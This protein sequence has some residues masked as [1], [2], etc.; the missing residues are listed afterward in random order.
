MMLPQLAGGVMFPDDNLPE[1][2]KLKPDFGLRCGRALWSRYSAGGTYFSFNQLPEMQETRN[3]G[4][5]MQSPEKYKNWFTNGSPIGAKSISQNEAFSST[6]GMSR[7]QRKALVNISYD[8]F[9]P[10]RKLSNVLLSVLSDND[11]KVKC[12]SLDKNI[13]NKKRDKKLDIQVKSKYTNPLLESLNLPKFQLPF[14][15]KDD[16]MIE[17]ADRLGFFKTKYEV[18]FEKIAEAGF[19]SS[20]WANMRRDLNRDAIDFHFRAAKI[21]NDE[22]TG[23]VK[24]QYID[25]ARLVMLWNEDNQDDPVAI[26]HIAVETIQSMYPKLKEAGFSDEKIQAMA[27]SYV[28]YQTDVTSL[29]QWAFEKKDPT[30]NRW[31]WMDFKVYVLKFEYLSTDYKQFVERENKHGYVTYLRNNKPVEEKKKNPNETYDEFQCN[32]WYEGSYII[33]GTGQDM[34]YEWRKKPNQM[35]KGLTPLSSYVVHRIGGQSPTRSVKGL[36]DDLMFAI[37][38]LRAAVWAAAP[39]GYRIDVSESAN[40]K[41]GGVEY[42]L[43]DLIHVHRQNGI[44]VVATKFNAA[45]GKY[46]SQPVTEMDN[47]LG[48]QGAEWIQQIANIQMMVKDL[49]GIPDAMAASP[50]QSAERLVGVVEQDYI[51]GNHANWPL[52]ESERIFKQKVAEKIIH[53]ARIDIEFDEKIRE[54]YSS[55]IG[56][57]MIDSLD[58][59]KG[60][61]L[62]QLAITTRALPNEKE[63]GMILQRAIQM[64]QIPTKDGSVMLRPS[65]IER[66]AQLLKNDD[67]DEAVWFMAVEENEARQREEQYAQQSMIQNAQLQQQS[68]MAAEQARRETIMMEAQMAINLEREKANVELMKQMQIQKMKN[69]GAYQIQLI[70]AKQELDAIE[71]EAKLESELGNEITGRI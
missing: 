44:Q 25:P 18:A 22:L 58:E 49:M 24:V 31:V 51:A 67:V 6:R 59:V 40:I 62:D 30:T 43:F 39:K 70:K 13:V 34:I 50:D 15:P 68:A 55:M 60:L 16:M 69:D 8:I 65:S 36:L 53:Q 66:I 4:A 21:Y 56:E 61:S 5:G 19:R 2:E 33:S 23:Q 54:F 64:S 7:A 47:G 29:P 71:L 46:V 35:Q 14:V 63:K 26:G 42:D 38:K 27:K 32:Y 3:Y 20:D 45:S 37:L 9:S 48:P 12:V 10:M 1:S 11:Y 57:Y 17:M 52:R 41:I 28:P